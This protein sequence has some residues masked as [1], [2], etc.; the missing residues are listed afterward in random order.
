LKRLENKLRALGIDAPLL[1][2]NSNGGLSSAS[3]AQERLVFF[4]SSGRASGAARLGAA[5]GEENLV[6]FDMGG[7]TAFGLNYGIRERRAAEEPAWLR[8]VGPCHEAMGRTGG[9]NNPGIATQMCN[10]LWIGKNRL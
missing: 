8:Y 9:R 4:I 7:T 3:V 6:A 5:L 2:G 1:I 10:R